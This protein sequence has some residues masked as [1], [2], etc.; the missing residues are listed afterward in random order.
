MK[1]RRRTLSSLVI[2]LALIAGAVAFIA[3]RG[4]DKQAPDTDTT[5]VARVGSVGPDAFSASYA[6]AAATGRSQLRR[7]KSIQ[8]AI[9]CTSYLDARTAVR[10]PICATSRA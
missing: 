3:T 9:S 5:Y 8:A 10:A 7:V 6:T 2:L 4:D 1:I